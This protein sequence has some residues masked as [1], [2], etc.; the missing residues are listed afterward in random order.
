MADPLAGLTASQQAQLRL[1][2]WVA[3]AD[4]EFA[5]EERELLARLAGRLMPDLDPAAAVERLVAEDGGDLEGLVAQ[6]SGEDDRQ[7]LVKLAF[8]MVCSSREPGDNTL[9]NSAEQRA[10]RRLLDA[11][12]L[13]DSEVEEAE[14]AARQ[15]LRETPAL[16]DR[17]NQMLF[18]WGA[19]PSQEALRFSGTT[20]L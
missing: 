16:I 1:V 13:P 12:A 18:G 19:W 7:L 14:W 8:Q 3:C 5:A 10:Y 11:L 17:L 6:L 20:W 9:I 15:A 2:C 4:G